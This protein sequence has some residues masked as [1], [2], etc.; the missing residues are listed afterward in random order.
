MPIVPSFPPSFPILKTPNPACPAC[1]SGK[2]HAPEETRVYH[3]Q[4]GHGYTP[5]KGWTKKYMEPRRSRTSTPL[6]R[7]EL[8]TRRLAAAGD[9][10]RMSQ[11]AVARKY[12]VSRTTA[13]R[14]TRMIKSGE[15]LKRRKTPGRRPR[16]NEQQ[17]AAAITLWGT[18]LRWTTKKFC[19]AILEQTGVKY[20][21]D[22]L[23]RLIIRWGLRT[24]RHRA[25][26]GSKRDV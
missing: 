18:R 6:T 17:R 23:S 19:A 4:S 5:E 1:Q 2:R 24:K 26:N 12:G 25:P 14:W 20:Q 21:D 22:H 7:D 13:S 9:F 11:A 8:E 10:A 16:L 15:S 3:P